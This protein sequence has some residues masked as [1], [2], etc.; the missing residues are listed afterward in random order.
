V[1][2][3]CP[4]GQ[5]SHS[6]GKG[7]QIPAR[8]TRHGSSLSITSEDLVR[9]LITPLSSVLPTSLFLHTYFRNEH[10]SQWITH[11]TRT[12]LVHIALIYTLRRW[13]LLGSSTRTW[14]YCFGT[15]CKSIRWHS[16]GSIHWH[17]TVFQR[18]LLQFMIS[19]AVS[20]EKTDFKSS[21]LL[22]DLK[23]TFPL[24]WR[25]ATLHPGGKVHWEWLK[26]HSLQMSIP[27]SAWKSGLRT[28]KRPQKDR[29]K[30]WKDRTSSPG[31]LFL[32]TWDR[33]KT[34]FN[35]PV[36]PVRTGLL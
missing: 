34:G 9:A 5:I 3:A 29:T 23:T 15:S 26:L 16:W 21:P 24:T 17:F 11:M 8:N 1:V 27:T 18:I 32:R 25:I 14:G 13:W 6:S 33:K 4:L 10:S 31:L 22:V 28:A 12:R 7:P 36:W 35:E 20:L 19:L 30:T 2:H